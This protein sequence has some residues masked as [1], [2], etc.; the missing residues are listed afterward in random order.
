MVV[1]RRNQPIANN[2]KR[3]ILS[4][5]VKSLGFIILFLPV[6]CAVRESIV[7]TETGNL[8]AGYDKK[9]AYVI[10]KTSKSE[11]GPQRINDLKQDGLNFRFAF[12]ETGSE[13]NGA[14]VSVSVNG[15]FE[16]TK[17]LRVGD[18]VEK[19]LQLYGKP[20]AREVDYG[21]DWPVHYTLNGLF[22]RDLLILTDSSGA[23]VSGMAVGPVLDL[24]R[25]Y[26]VRR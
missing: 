14:I 17:G 26:I 6:S 11:I 1:S 22:Y 12:N 23:I 2:M 15:N 13:Q 16:T 25:K 8:I 10:G 9:C 20:R 19:A 18:P 3:Y 4:G 24:R 7:E 5:A 21:R